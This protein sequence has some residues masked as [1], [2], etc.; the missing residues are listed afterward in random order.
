MAYLLTGVQHLKSGD[1]IMPV[2]SYESVDE[3]KEKYHREMQYAINNGDFLG[4]GI[5]V[6]ND[7]TLQDVFVDIWV[8]ENPDTVPNVED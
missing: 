6:F 5:K 4:L 3:W 8:R 1:A 2:H 7:A